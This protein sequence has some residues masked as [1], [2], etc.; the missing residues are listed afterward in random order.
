MKNRLK[1][2]L[3]ISTTALALTVS[4]AAQATN[5]YFAH[6]YGTKTKGMAGAGV[7]HG[8][9][10]MAAATNPA[11]MVLAGDRLDGGLAWFHPEREYTVAGA[12][13]GFPGTF[14]LNPKTTQSRS[15]NFF[16]PHIG[17]NKMINPN[18]SVGV[19]IYGNG[20]MNT[21]YFEFPNQLFCTNPGP[22]PTPVGS[23]TGPF[24]AGKAGVNLEQLFIAPTF[25]HKVSIPT[26]SL[27]YGITPI[28]AFQRFA[29]DGIA[30]FAPFSADPAHLTNNGHSKSDGFGF[31]LGVMAD[32]S[33][34]LT[35][36]VSYQSEI[37]MDKFDEYAGL[38]A[39]Q[40]D[41][42]IPSTWTIG[43]SWRPS[44]KH[45]VVFDV[46]RINYT[47]VQS[48]SNPIAN[49]ITPPPAPFGAD[50]GP[51]FGWED[52]TI[53]KLGYE[54]SVAS[55]PDWTWRLGVSHGDQPIPDSEVTFNTFAPAVIEDHVTFG[56]T[57]KSGSN[58]EF[59][60]AAMHAL[61]NSVKGPHAFDP[62]Q[63]VEIEMDQFEL[64]GSIGWKF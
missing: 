6:G 52:M 38:F 11:G 59:S 27:S 13:S 56:F 50:G 32:V 41:F 29:A 45:A 28:Y 46:Q 15:N 18:M 63:T 44:A 51:G 43:L 14:P 61:H 3:L 40:G 35:L 12:P 31:K 30:T 10:S 4:G 2:P 8:T 23:Q 60:L 64:E 1:F 9:D 55:L 62:G 19:S 22:P 34:T 24:C 21:D 49:L 42:D 54:F 58:L 33:P 37:D 7:A 16:I 25:A 39:E 53:Y 57:K 48:V 20:G 36:G 47:D 17:Y 26:G 5:G